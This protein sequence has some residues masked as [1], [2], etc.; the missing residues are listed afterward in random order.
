MC[1]RDSYISEGKVKKPDILKVPILDEAK[2]TSAGKVKTTR[3]STNPQKPNK[4]TQPAINQTIKKEKLTKSAIPK[5]KSSIQGAPFVPVSRS[6]NKKKS[7]SHKFIELKIKLE[8]LTNQD[9]YLEAIDLI[10]NSELYKEDCCRV[11]L[12]RKRTI[13]EN[14]INIS[15]QLV[16][17]RAM[18]DNLKEV[19]NCIQQSNCQC[20]WDYYEKAAKIA[21][22]DML[23]SLLEAAYSKVKNCT[24]KLELNGKKYISAVL[25]QH[26]ETNVITKREIFS[27]SIDEMN[28]KITI[29]EGNNKQFFSIKKI[30]MREREMRKYLVHNKAL[31]EMTI[32]C[33]FKSNRL[34]LTHDKN[35][36]H[37]NFNK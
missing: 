21:N 37:Y 6:T 25:I 10:I 20:A 34:T 19:D 33:N 4:N 9:K 23:K 14:K 1:I 31:E 2:D 11:E 32:S 30:S 27:I 15:P 18:D 16:K 5:E 22:D 3:K 17:A 36:K 29:K 35:I 13:Y 8:K 24:A 7:K 12:E 26:T 28:K